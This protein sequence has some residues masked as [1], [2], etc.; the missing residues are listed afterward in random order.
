MVWRLACAVT[1]WFLLVAG[2]QAAPR[3]LVVGDSLS[4]AYGIPADQGWVHLLQQRLAANGHP[5][6]VV[7]ASITGD[8]TRGG[9]ARLPAVLEHHQPEVVVLELGGNDGLRGFGPA[10][11]HDH[12][13]QM[14]RL[15][16][17]A[18]ARVLVLG[19]KL[20]ANYGS[21]YGDKFHQVFLDLAEQEDVVVVPF[22]LQGVAEDRRL[23]QADGIHPSA[24]AQ[25]LILDNVWSALEPLLVAPHG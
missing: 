7:N 19:V 5:H 14:I 24:A 9:L 2:A 25:P 10:M 6:Q 4:A 15:A 8:T 1:I 21:A 23:M 12:L 16:T 11:T 22:F 20:P 13:Q 18:G 17:A 3:L